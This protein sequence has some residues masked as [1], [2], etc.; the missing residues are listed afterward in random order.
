MLKYPQDALKRERQVKDLSDQRPPAGPDEALR[1]LLSGG[2][3]HSRVVTSK[4][5]VMQF[6]PKQVRRA[7]ER[8]EVV[9]RRAGS[10][11]AMHTTWEL[12]AALA[13]I[14]PM[15]K[16]AHRF[17]PQQ[18]PTSTSDDQ[19]ALFRTPDAPNLSDGELRRVAR[20]TEYF[21]AK[22]LGR[23]RA[24]DLALFLVVERDREGLQVMSCAEC[25]NFNSHRDCRAAREGCPVVP[26]EV[27]Q[28]WYCYLA[29]Q[30][31]Q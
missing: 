31:V 17:V 9:A 11:R 27:S 6:T 7:R 28:L 25:Q 30:G 22:G 15:S 26:R 3:Q 12:P 4:M 16:S 1:E 18:E 24:H 19:A 21:E 8:L 14:E 5:V 2:A 29:R 10:G 20:R 23:A 13:A